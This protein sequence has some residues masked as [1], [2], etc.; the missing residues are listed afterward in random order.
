M[1][2]AK[3]QQSWNEKFAAYKA[4]PQLAEEF[5][6]RMSGGLPKDWEKRLRNI[7]MSYRQIRRKKSLPVRLRKITCPNAYG[8]DAAE[9]L[10]GSGGSAPQPDHLQGSVS[11][12]EDPA[13]TTFTTGCVN[14]A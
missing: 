1:K 9:L 14:L 10:G 8:P 12:K 6:R 11:L 4:D 3:A 7:S 13:A 2:K 5:T